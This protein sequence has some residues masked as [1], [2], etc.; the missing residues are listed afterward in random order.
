MDYSNPRLVQLRKLGQRV[1][2]LRPMVRLFRRLRGY[3]YED[4]F[5][6]A[7]LGHLRAGQTIWDVG[8]NVGIYV[9]LFAQAA[10]PEGRVVAFEPSPD[11]YKLLCEKFAGRQNI[12]LKNVALA[13]REGTA[14]FYAAE[15]GGVTDGLSAKPGLAMRESKV[16]VHTGDSY[17]AQ[18]PPDLI[19]IDI[20]G[21]ELEALQGM[22][23]VLTSPRPL[24]VFLEVH[25]A[26]LNGRGIPDAATRITGL[27]RDAGFTIDWLDPSHL[28]ASR[29]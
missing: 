1:G 18:F 15:G 6:A 10:G 16:D 11:N 9:E 17:L 3:D 29:T 23:A 26:V 28:L 21:Y 14:S 27:L 13:E 20:E 5:H 25:F 8:A 7:L 12:V 22:K 24:L 4:A 19:K 2:V